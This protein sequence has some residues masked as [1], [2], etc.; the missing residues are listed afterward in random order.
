VLLTV[1]ADHVH[2]VEILVNL[3]HIGIQCTCTKVQ[4]ACVAC[5]MLTD[6][7]SAANSRDLVSA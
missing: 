1:T 7:V 5:L 2:N 6:K 3:V 4:S